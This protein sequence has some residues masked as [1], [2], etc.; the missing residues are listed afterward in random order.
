MTII[1]WVGGCLFSYQLLPSSNI[2]DILSFIF[3][4]TFIVLCFNLNFIFNASFL[5]AD[6][7]WVLVQLHLCPNYHQ[8]NDNFWLLLY[9]SLNWDTIFRYK[10]YEFGKI[11]VPRHFYFPSATGYLHREFLE[12]INI[13]KYVR[14]IPFYT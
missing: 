11:I 13:N 6:Q 4:N 8:V 12:T 1:N 10:K 7:C 2:L 5:S 9:F 3:G 14:C